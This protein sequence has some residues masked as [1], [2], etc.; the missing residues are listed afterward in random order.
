MICSWLADCKAL[1]HG[2]Y[3]SGKERMERGLNLIR[4]GL[5]VDDE[6]GL[7][8]AVQLVEDIP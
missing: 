7:M 8:Q 1:F 5:D 6:K 2:I 3:K 4:D